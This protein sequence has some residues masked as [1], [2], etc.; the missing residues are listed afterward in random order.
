M[1]ADSLYSFIT[2]QSAITTITTRIYPVIL[3]Q[4][5]TFPAITYREDSHS[6]DESFDGQTGLT[7]S[8][9]L[10]DAWAATYSG[11]TSL[12]DVI[13]S[14][15]K[16]HSGNMGSISVM[17]VTLETGPVTVYEDEVEAYR[18]TQVFSIWHNEV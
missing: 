9:Y 10:F 4:E 5:P 13:R 6:L 15:L 2:A 1:I 3:P 8:F 7:Q 17:K 16:N 14:S 12:G 11:V 18:Q